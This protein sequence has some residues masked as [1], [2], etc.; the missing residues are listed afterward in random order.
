MTTGALDHLGRLLFLGN[1]RAR[2][3]RLDENLA[4]ELPCRVRRRLIC[5]DG[6]Q[7]TKRT[8]SQAPGRRQKPGCGPFSTFKTLHKVEDVEKSL[9]QV[10]EGKQANRLHAM[11]GKLENLQAAVER[12]IRE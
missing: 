1:P 7:E 9:Q 4:M 6:I 3:W 11:E 5:T 8:G 10:M 2:V 12:R